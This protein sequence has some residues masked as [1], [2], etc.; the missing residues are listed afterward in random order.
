MAKHGKFEIMLI[1]AGVPNANGNVYTQEATEALA[2]QCAGKNVYPCLYNPYSQNPLE[3]PE[4]IGSIEHGHIENGNLKVSINIDDKCA[5]D[6]LTKYPNM[7]SI[8]ALTSHIHNIEGDSNWRFDHAYIE[9]IEQQP[10]RRGVMGISDRM[11]A[12]LPGQKIGDKSHV[13]TLTIDEA[14][15]LAKDLERACEEAIDHEMILPARIYTPTDRLV[16]QVNPHLTRGDDIRE[17]DYA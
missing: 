15:L 17:L 1:K 14:K 12:A 5:V 9:G 2:A 6:L 13:V 8:R 10:E 11:S 7:F 16:I 4:P 3:E